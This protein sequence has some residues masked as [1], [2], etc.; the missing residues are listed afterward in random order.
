MHHFY[1]YPI[2]YYF[3]SSVEQALVWLGGMYFSKAS[4]R[5]SI[6]LFSFLNETPHQTVGTCYG[7]C[8]KFI[9]MPMPNQHGH[10]LYIS[11]YFV[12]VGGDGGDG[13]TRWEIFGVLW[14]IVE[15]LEAQMKPWKIVYI[16]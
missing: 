8:Y 4:L 6:D 5:K 2:F 1:K 10:V 15:L 7:R 12:C 3:F 9:L 11:E 16:C 14:N 13:G